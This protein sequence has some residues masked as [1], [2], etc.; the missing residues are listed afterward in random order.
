MNTNF[1]VQIIK[2]KPFIMVFSSWIE[3]LH[4]LDY[5][6][7]PVIHGIGIDLTDYILN[8]QP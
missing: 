8:I 6:L 1:N 7:N 4:D 5:V 2:Y 3:H